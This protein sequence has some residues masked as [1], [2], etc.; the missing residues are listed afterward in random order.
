[1]TDR[2]RWRQVLPIIQAF[3]DGK[4]IQKFGYDKRWKDTDRMVSVMTGGKYRVKPEQSI[5]GT[6]TIRYRFKEAGTIDGPEGVG[7]MSWI[8]SSDE[9]PPWPKRNEYKYEED[10]QWFTPDIKFDV[11]EEE[12]L[13][14]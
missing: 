7:I 11:N 1:M 12:I 9:V 14:D 5:K 10:S 2:Y 6:W 3:V 4:D 13:E 8:G